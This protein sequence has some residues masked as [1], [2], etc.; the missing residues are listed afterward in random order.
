[1]LSQASVLLQL[2]SDR[3]AQVNEFISAARQLSGAQQTARR[4]EQAIAS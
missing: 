4:T 1:M 2:S 3:S